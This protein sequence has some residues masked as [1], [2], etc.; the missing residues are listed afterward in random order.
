[1]Q[2][3]EKQRLWVLFGSQLLWHHRFPC[4]A[5]GYSSSIHIY[6]T[7]A[8]PVLAEMTAALITSAESFPSSRA[9]LTAIWC[10]KDY[11][12]EPEGLSPFTTSPWLL[13]ELTLLSWLLASGWGPGGSCASHRR[14][15]THCRCGV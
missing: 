2:K 3:E 4:P 14:D 1:M 9:A 7:A 8:P 11:K 10:Y 15:R 12:Q 5:D 13:H 6:G